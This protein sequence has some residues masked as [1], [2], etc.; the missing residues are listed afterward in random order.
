[1]AVNLSSSAKV[2]FK[3]LKV[4]DMTSNLKNASV[5]VTSLPRATL[6]QLHHYIIPTLIDN[7]PDTIITQG[8]C[9]DVSNKNSNPKDIA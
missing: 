6:K 9:N 2:W 3:G 5:R 4:K 8:E 7:T 1:M